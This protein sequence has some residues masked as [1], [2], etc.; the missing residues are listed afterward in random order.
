MYLLFE[1]VETKIYIFCDA[2]ETTECVKI[3]V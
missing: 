1:F 3:T 2:T